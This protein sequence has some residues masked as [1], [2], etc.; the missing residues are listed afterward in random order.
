MTENTLR[1]GLDRTDVRRSGRRGGQGWLPAGVS[2]RPTV[3]TCV[4][5]DDTRPPDELYCYMTQDYIRLAYVST[6][7]QL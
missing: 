3:N 4:H 6:I 5:S 2:D 1:P 7:G